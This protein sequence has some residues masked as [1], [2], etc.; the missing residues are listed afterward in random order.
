MKFIDDL[1]V[2][3]ALRLLRGVMVFFGGAAAGEDAVRGLLS[4]S[5]Y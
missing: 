5:R 3:L 1:I 4:S 2:T